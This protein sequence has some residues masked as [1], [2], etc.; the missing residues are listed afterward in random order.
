[1]S[2]KIAAREENNRLEKVCFVT[3]DGTDSFLE[4][5]RSNVFENDQ[6]HSLI[7]VLVRRAIFEVFCLKRFGSSQVAFDKCF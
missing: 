1:M 3:Q 4:R 2:Q 6:A 5:V 7:A